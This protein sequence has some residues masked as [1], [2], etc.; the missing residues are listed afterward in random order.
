MD[1]DGR[2]DRR[3]AEV[4]ISSSTTCWQRFGE[5]RRQGQRGR[6]SALK[7]NGYRRATC[8]TS[9]NRLGLEQ[10]SPTREP[11]LLSSKRTFQG[12]T[13]GRVEK[14]RPDGKLEYS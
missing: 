13:Q 4:S 11:I 1:E 2:V 12:I 8:F 3:E 6:P 14:G 7:V 9:L 10:R 5:K